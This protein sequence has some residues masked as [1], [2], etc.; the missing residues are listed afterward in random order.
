MSYYKLLNKFD[1]TR[2]S[3]ISVR[4]EY[5]KKINARELNYMYDKRVQPYRL[6]LED[7]WIKNLVFENQIKCEE[8]LKNEYAFMSI[9]ELENKLKK[10][11]E[12]ICV[13]EYRDTLNEE[14]MEAV[15]LLEMIGKNQREEVR[16]EYKKEL[17]R[18]LIQQG[19]EVSDE[20]DDDEDWNFEE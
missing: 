20:E 3:H 14:W 19:A 2:K 8:K 1:K 7:E 10:R 16:G 15:T 6:F 18:K 11:L 9:N 4:D 13:S 17:N 12:W 5:I